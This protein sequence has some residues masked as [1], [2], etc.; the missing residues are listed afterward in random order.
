MSILGRFADRDCPKCH[1]RGIAGAS[2]PER[3]EC[4]RVH[5]VHRRLTQQVTNLEKR[6][7]DM[8]AQIEAQAMSEEGMIAYSASLENE[9]DELMAI[10]GHIV[11]TNGID[12]FP[13][14]F[15][16]RIRKALG[17]NEQGEA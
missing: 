8:S 15:A 1:G 11:A 4:T 17:L 6:L 10:L 7:S 14:P 2:H 13:P 16:R 12:A 9:R 3:C 5:A